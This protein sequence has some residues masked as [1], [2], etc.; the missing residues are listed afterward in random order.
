MSNLSKK[1]LIDSTTFQYGMVINLFAAVL[2]AVDPSF[3]AVDVI[4][5]FTMTFGA[6]VAKEGV[7]KGAEAY[8]DRA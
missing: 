5:V 8:R 3:R 7:A 6:Y 2:Y 1:R 4:G